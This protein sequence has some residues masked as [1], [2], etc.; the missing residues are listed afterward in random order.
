MKVEERIEEDIL[1]R[2]TALGKL[3]EAEYKRVKELTAAAV[4]Q[5]PGCTYVPWKD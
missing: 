1:E 5:G 3:S 2:A 4:A